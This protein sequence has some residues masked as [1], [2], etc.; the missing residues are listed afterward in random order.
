MEFLNVDDLL[1]HSYKIHPQYI[2]LREK[3]ENTCYKILDVM[4]E[5]NIVKDVTL[6]NGKWLPPIPLEYRKTMSD[7]AKEKYRE[8]ENIKLQDG[9]YFLESLKHRKESSEIVAWK[10]NDIITTIDIQTLKTYMLN[11]ILKQKWKC[12]YCGNNNDG[13]LHCRGIST[14]LM[15]SG[16]PK[17]ANNNVLSEYEYFLCKTASCQPLIHPFKYEANLG[18]Y[19]PNSMYKYKKLVKG[20]PCGAH[21]C[22]HYS[23]INQSDQILSFPRVKWTP[24]TR[25]IENTE[26]FFLPGAMLGH[27]ISKSECICTKCRNFVTI[28]EIPKHIFRKEI[29]HSWWILETLYWIKVDIYNKKMQKLNISQS[30]IRYDELVNSIHTIYCSEIDDYIYHG[31]NGFYQTN[32]FKNIIEILYNWIMNKQNYINRFSKKKYSKIPLKF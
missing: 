7:E 14:G 11:F 18:W 31:K 9:K 17:K 25:N 4:V 8:Y 10:P 15:P 22:I 29:E 30:K 5:N 21:R 28:S 24:R 20:H 26:Q 32:K 3:D 12:R 23:H 1:T 6:Q 16:G 13:G 19:E 27:H 2:W